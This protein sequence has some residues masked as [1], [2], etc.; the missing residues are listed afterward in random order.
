M[1]KK[2]A[3]W[4]RHQGLADEGRIVPQVNGLRIK[5]LAGELTDET[6]EYQREGTR[7]R[8]RDGKVGEPTPTPA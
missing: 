3:V 5:E 2:Y 7:R 8:V 1:R 4:A 6:N